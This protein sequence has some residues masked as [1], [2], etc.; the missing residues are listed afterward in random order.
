MTY[1]VNPTH[2]TPDE[3][4]ALLQAMKFDHGWT[5][6][7]PTLHNTGRPSLRQWRSWG[8]TP[9]ERWGNNLNN[10]YR[11]KGWHSGV[12][13]VACPD[14]IWNLCDLRSDGI[15]VSCWNRVAI[16]IEMVGNYEIGGDEFDCGD[17]SKVRDNAVWALAVLCEKF[18]WDIGSKLHFHRDCPQ[19][20]H[21]C[22]GSLVDKAHVA[23]LVKARLASWGGYQP[24]PAPPP[25]KPPL[26][27]VTTVRGLQ[28]ALVSLGFRL[29]VD[30]DYGPETRQAVT[31]FQMHEGIVADGL[32]GPQTEA[33]LVKALGA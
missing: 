22:P 5:P 18:G 20:G 2:Y 12:H 29:T 25:P 15:S 3:F 14:Y 13:L 6:E 30:G 11:G 16:G 7:F 10:F 31:S 8:V 28:Q 33:A 1:L 24:A 32:C 4:R 21:Q 23:A 26:P 19:D 27:D 9:Q 17:G